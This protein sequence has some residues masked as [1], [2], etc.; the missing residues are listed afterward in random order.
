MGRSRES[1]TIE[2]VC[3]R[4][5]ETTTEYVSMTIPVDEVNWAGDLVHP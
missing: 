5:R 3:L 4:D 2:V 1:V